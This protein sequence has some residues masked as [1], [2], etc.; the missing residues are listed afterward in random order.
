MPSVSFTQESFAGGMNL[1]DLGVKV[2]PD[3]YI[4]G[5][6]LRSRFGYL[7]AVKEPIDQT[8]DLPIT[9]QV[10]QGLYA[11]GEILICFIGGTAYYKDVSIDDGEWI[12][13]EGFQ[14]STSV[15]RIYAQAVPSADLLY[16]R[17]NSST[18]KPE[19]NVILDPTNTTGTSQVALV[20]QDGVNQPWLIFPD[21]TSRVSQGY[22][23]W[24]V[25]AREYIPIGKQMV[26]SDGRLYIVSA[27]GR[28]IYRSVTGRPLDFVIAINQTGAA[29][30]DA[31][32]LSFAVDSNEIKLIATSNDEAN[33]LIVITA[34]SAYLSTP[35]FTNKIYGEPRFF[36]TFLF[37]AGTI[38]QFCMADL[39]G[40]AAFIDREGLKS[41]NSVKQLKFEGNNSVF[42]LGISKLFTGIVQDDNACVGS[43]DNYTYFAVQTTYSPAS[44]IVYDSVK[45]VFSSVDLFSSKPIKQFATTYSA[46]RQRLF[47]A[48]ENSILELYSPDSTEPLSATVFT[49]EVDS[50]STDQGP[51]DGVYNIKPMEARMIF[52][53]GL[54]D[55]EVFLDVFVNNSKQEGEGH[56]R[57]IP[58]ATGGI[59]FPVT[60]PVMFT[61][62]N[63]LIPRD[64]PM[65]KCKQ[66]QKIGYSITWTGGA[67]LTYFIARAD[68]EKSPTSTQQQASIYA[69]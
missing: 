4:I 7:E 56:T 19:G 20:C 54:E 38:N 37:T 48:T 44:V 3:Q 43:Y 51:T 18:N 10:I 31:E 28:K 64:I 60:F 8:G 62:E 25:T 13:I 16:L 65:K 42:S 23:D 22:T 46:A 5:I 24:D 50:R 49:R 35:D 39:L 47:A 11:F 55:G 63:G 1:V 68:C 52:E 17:Q 69:S 57:T 34:Y 40:D 59:L 12:L 29:V 30:A 36:R 21:G 32:P 58:Q 53:E 61:V 9:G 2:A 14:L 27:D 26:Y 67:K 33:S 41:F 45:K 15:T 66:G 6:N